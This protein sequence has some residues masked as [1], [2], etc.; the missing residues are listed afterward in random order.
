MAVGA[1]PNAMDHDMHDD[2]LTGPEAHRTARRNTHQANW[3]NK[4]VWVANNLLVIQH[5]QPMGCQSQSDQMKTASIMESNGR[6]RLMT[7]NNFLLLFFQLSAE[8]LKDYEECGLKG[9]KIVSGP[10]LF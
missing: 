9:K 4:A 10:L 7:P 3:Q 1:S 2:P 8:D 6:Q 5:F